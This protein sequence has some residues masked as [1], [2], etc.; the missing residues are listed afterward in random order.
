MSLRIKRIQRIGRT[1]KAS[2]VVAASGVIMAASC[3]RDDDALVA[4]SAGGLVAID[5]TLGEVEFRDVDY[6]LTSDNFNRYV[7]AQDAIDALPQPPVV[8]RIDVRAPRE[9]DVVMVVQ[10]LESDEPARLAI[11]NS[12]LSVRDFVLTSLALGQAL[13][14]G[15]DQRVVVQPV[16]RLFLE[17]NRL[18]IDRLESRRRF[19]IGEREPL[20]I[21]IRE[22]VDS[23]D[24]DDNG[25]RVQRRGNDNANPGLAKGHAKPKGN[26]KGKGKGKG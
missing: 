8:Q 9:D 7:V 23:D 18:V 5:T 21:K 1:L 19:R 3:S 24:D 11:A 4:D 17:D 20:R 10:Q 6:R 12:G 2:A 22:D 25:R 13:A 14:F 16:N 26:G 15:N